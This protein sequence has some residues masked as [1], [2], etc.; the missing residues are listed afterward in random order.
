MKKKKILFLTGIRSDFY[1]QKPIIKAVNSSKKLKSYLVVSGAHLSKQFG[2]TYKEIVREK[3]N[4]VGKIKNLE[5]SDKYSSR[6]KSASKQLAGL[7]KIVNKVKPDIIIAPYDR[8]ESITSAL[9]GAYLNIPVAHLGA[10]DRT[11]V[12]VDGVIRHSVSKLSNIFLCFT[13]ENARRIIKMGEEKWRVFN[14]GHTAFDRYKN[15]NKISDKNLSKYLNL[16]ITSEPLILV[17]QHPVSNWKNKTADHFKITLSAVDELNYPTIVIRSNS[18][19]GSVSMKSIFKKFKFTNKKIRY[20]EN[21][22]ETIFSNIMLKTRVLLGNS[23]MG[24]LEA[25]FL[26]LPV[27]N[28]GLRQKDRQNAGNIIFVP[29]KK[30]KIINAVQKC[31]RNKKFIKKIKNLKNPY[32]GD[33]ANKIVKILSNIK[34]NTKLKNKIITY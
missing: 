1:I 8:E 19:P 6:L 25:P 22:P 9:T 13:K 23:S 12:N 28:V 32:K 10:G 30:K 21:I 3:F 2:F 11:R 26:K 4:I 33:A 16:D 7:A 29:H 31:L 5:L 27:V 20:F 34:I 17:V 18:D 15:I 14:V 24:V